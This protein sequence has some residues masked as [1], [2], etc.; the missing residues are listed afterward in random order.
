[1]LSL[2]LPFSNSTQLRV[3]YLPTPLMKQSISVA[4]PNLISLGTCF[5]R[6][7]KSG[8]FK[9]AVTSLDYLAKYAKFKVRFLLSLSHPPLRFLLSV[10]SL[11][12]SLSSQGFAGGDTFG[13]GRVIGGEDVSERWRDWCAGRETCA[14]MA[15]RVL[16]GKSAEESW[17]DVFSSSLSCS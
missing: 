7:S 15:G 10:S 11:V 12:R 6:F 17:S 16:P 13:V 9:L 2:E 14:T 8:K 3:Y 1:M 5:G 4:R